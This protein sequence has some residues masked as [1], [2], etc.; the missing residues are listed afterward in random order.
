MTSEPD[1][2]KLRSFDKT[3]AEQ[4]HPLCYNDG[5]HQL[6]YFG[7]PDAS[8]NVVVTNKTNEFCVFHETFLRLA[9][10]FWIYG[11]PIYKGDSVYSQNGYYIDNEVVHGPFVVRQYNDSSVNAH[12]TICSGIAIA[13]QIPLSDLTV[14]L[15]TQKREKKTV[16][17]LAFIMANGILREV[18]EGSESHRNARAAR[19]C[20]VPS[21]DSIVVVE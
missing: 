5:R 13:K 8:G 11:T 10:L 17:L 6:K 3:L 20:R 12:F 9:P 16:Q 18:A 7:G 15:P 21:R 1:Y 14:S 19:L 2:T 4:G